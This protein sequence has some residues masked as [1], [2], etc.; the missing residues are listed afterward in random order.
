[1]SRQAYY[2]REDEDYELVVCKRF[3]LELVKEI[4]GKA[5]KIGCL[6]L[7]LMCKAK[8]GEQMQMGRDTFYNFLRDNGLMLR[9]KIRRKIKTTF[10]G[11]GYRLYPNLIR[12]FIPTAINQL[13]VSDI[14]YIVI[15]NKFVYLTL[16]TDAYSH[17]I[18]GYCLAPSLHA[19]YTQQA[20]Q[21]AIAAATERGESLEGLI[22][23]SDRGVQYA[24][25]GYVEILQQANI[26]I[27]MTENG[28]PLE[29]AVAERINGILKTEF[30]NQHDFM[31][32]EE[33]EKVL[34]PS[35][36]F[37]NNER[38]HMSI[39]NLTPLQARSRTGTLTRH[40]KGYIPPNTTSNPTESD[41][42]G[43]T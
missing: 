9:R 5:S 38:P 35:I 13:W 43:E 24:C 6:K 10:S 16:I 19:I 8:F 28:D 33:V 41:P 3:V 11:H 21:M 31:N 1:M 12:G 4:R 42:R 18:I 22:H 32:I 29:N 17:Q 30:L 27:S 2:Q 20:L 39:D 23:H 14:T 26:R 36:E 37:Y 15:D 34:Y 40:W 25:G 7:H